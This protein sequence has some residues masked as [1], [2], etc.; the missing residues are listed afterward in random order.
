MN[1]CTAGVR[2]NQK[3]VPGTWY[4]F[5]AAHAGL[6]AMTNVIAAKDQR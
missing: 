1:F 5:S 2:K 3:F 6:C 4:L